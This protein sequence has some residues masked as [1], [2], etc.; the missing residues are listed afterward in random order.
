MRRKSEAFEKFKEFRAEAEKQLSKTIKTFRS[1]RGGEY[2]DTEFTDYLIENGIV[3]QL[4]APGDPQQ[5]G[6]AERRNRTLL[7]MMRS[8]I[9]YSSLPVNFWGYAISTAINILN[10]VPSKSISKTPLELWN[11]RKLS[12]R[13]YR[14]W[15]C[16]AHVLNKK[17]NKLESRTEVCLFVGYPK[18]TRGGIFYSPKDKKVFV[19][20]HATFLENDYVIGHKP[21]S[22]IILEELMG[23]PSFFRPTRVVDLRENEEMPSSSRSVR[24][25]DWRDEEEEEEQTTILN[26]N[27]PEPRRSGRTIRLPRRYETNVIVFDTNDDDPSSFKEAMI[28]SDKD[29]WQEAMNQ[30]MESM[31]SN[32]VWTLVDPPEGV[33]IIGCKW[34]YKKKRGADGEVETYKARLVAKGYTQREGID[35]E[36]TFSLVVMLKSI[37]ILLSI[38][39]CLDYEIWQMD[40]KTAFLNGYLEEDIY[41]AQPDG[42]INKDQQNKV[43]KLL[44]SI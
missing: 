36:E 31:D 38:A 26:Q 12:L 30:E 28:S 27:I 34:I 10:V 39:A 2:L 5:N 7:D 24:V 6:V 40:V 41:M 9:S 37:R 19:S 14:I 11:G 18:G 17:A 44:K 15:R 20:T 35:Y 29:K 21:R 8:M 22:K 32:S 33:R 23:S 3:S 42:F 16:P 4:S 13:H 25:T 1:D 43:C